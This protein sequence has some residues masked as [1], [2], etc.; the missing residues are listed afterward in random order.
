MMR[1]P[2]H[3]AESGA[4]ARQGCEI[5][6]RYLLAGHSARAAILERVEILNSAAA[7][8]QP[9]HGLARAK[10]QGPSSSRART[11]GWILS[12]VSPTT[13]AGFLIV[14]A[15]EPYRIEV[16]EQRTVGNNAAAMSASVVQPAWDS[17]LS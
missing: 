9:P 10:T 3:A 5:G 17:K 1:E 11:R 13:H 14:C 15:G 6:T 12:Q 16:L 8:F 7:K 4:E 2:A